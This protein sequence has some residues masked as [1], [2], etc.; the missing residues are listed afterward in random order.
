MR[1]Y[2]ISKPWFKKW[3][4]NYD[5]LLPIWIIRTNKNSNIKKDSIRPKHPQKLPKS[6][7]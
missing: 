1:Q 2:F 7:S 6:F 3:I 5:K 4:E